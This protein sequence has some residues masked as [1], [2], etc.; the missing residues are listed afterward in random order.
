[1]KLRMIIGTL[2]LTLMA[3]FAAFA[4]TS[5]DDGRTVCQQ[6]G[7]QGTYLSPVATAGATFA[8][9]LQFNTGGSVTYSGSYY[10]EQMLTEG[11]G[12][13]GVGTWQCMK[14]GS[15]AATIFFA[16]FAGTGSNLSLIYHARATMI[17]KFLDNG[18]IRREVLAVRIY[19]SND[20]PTDPS[21]GFIVNLPPEQPEYAKLGV[22]LSDLGL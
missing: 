17:F 8:D 14:D 21:A 15:I 2:V 7:W 5:D 9:Q 18:S 13:Q 11:T 19:F 20:D 16:N 6:V 22:S 4:T 10:P 3:S 1:M 12:S